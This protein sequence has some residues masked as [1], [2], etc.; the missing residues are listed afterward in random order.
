[1]LDETLGPNF[2]ALALVNRHISEE[3]MQSQGRNERE[4]EGV[5]PLFLC[6][7]ERIREIYR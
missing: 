7:F 6:P 1:M 4:G 2:I 3:Q 5:A